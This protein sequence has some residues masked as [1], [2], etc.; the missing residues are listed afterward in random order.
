MPQCLVEV[1]GVAPPEFS[2]LI[3]SQLRYYLRDKLPCLVGNP[4]LEPGK[5]PDPK[6]GVLATRPIPHIAA[7]YFFPY[8]TS[9][10]LQ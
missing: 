6:S 5:C 4:G 9:L 1:D 3:Y 10:S 8:A 7:A 2:Q